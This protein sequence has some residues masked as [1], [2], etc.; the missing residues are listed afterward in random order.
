VK[1]HQENDEK[2]RKNA[3]LMKDLVTER[4]KFKQLQEDKELEISDISLE[5]K[6]ARQKLTDLTLLEEKISMFITD[7]DLIIDATKKTMHDYLRNFLRTVGQS[8]SLCQKI[9]MRRRD[10]GYELQNK[11]CPK[12]GKQEDV[13]ASMVG[14]KD[15]QQLFGDTFAFLTEMLDVFLQNYVEL[16]SDFAKKDR[17][18]NQLET[19]LGNIHTADVQAQE[20]AMQAREELAESRKKFAE[21]EES[22]EHEIRVL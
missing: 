17:Q 4:D 18:L 2:L 13:W 16:N 21:M 19:K 20:S 9:N 3:I 14:F 11:L 1:Q 8:D 12:P 7:N 15:T 22:K 6:M 5:L 10:K